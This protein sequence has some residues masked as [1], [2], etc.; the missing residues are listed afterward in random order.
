MRL[1][2]ILLCAL[3]ALRSTENQA[4]FSTQLSIMPVLRNRGKKEKMSTSASNANAPRGIASR[5]G[6]S[7]TELD[8]GPGGIFT[9]FNAGG[10]LSSLATSAKYFF[11]VDAVGFAVSVVTKSHLHLDLVGTGAFVPA[12][13]ACIKNHLATNP[14]KPVSFPLLS[15]AMVI[16][17][18][19][20]RL[21]SFLFY[22]A[23][24]LK[25]D[26]RLTDTLSTMSGT[27][28]FWYVSALWGVFCTLPYTLAMAP[29]ARPPTPSKV[30]SMVSSAGF[31]IS[32][33]GLTIE[34]VAD[35]EKWL[36][37]MNNPSNTF[38]STGLW[39]VS[40][41]PN[42]FG[43]LLIFFGIFVINLQALS[44]TWWRV[45]GGALAPVFMLCLFYAQ[46][47]SLVADAVGLAVAKYGKQYEVWMENTPMVF[48]DF[49][50]YKN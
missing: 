47:Y 24:I 29:V 6:G 2:L 31:L 20:V 50:L 44:T 23:T 32:L 5:G 46:S 16:C 11:L 12:S 4:F 45:L 49:R 1:R 40:Q 14:G 27:A 33:A 28:G 42:Y 34:I 3:I 10:G 7:G 15:S 25:H 30:W 48:P 18:W 36:W 37:K 41:H 13:I 21:A 43:N 17:A 38:I 39:S 35:L 8:A 9:A 19:S 22:R 26:G